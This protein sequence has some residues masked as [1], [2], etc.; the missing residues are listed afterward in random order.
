LTHIHYKS[1]SLTKSRIDTYIHTLQV[2]LTH[3]LKVGSDML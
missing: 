2:I 1:H 3:S